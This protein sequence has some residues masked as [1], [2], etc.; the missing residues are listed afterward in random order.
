MVEI[1]MMHLYYSKIY[2]E[3]TN[4]QLINTAMKK[5]RKRK[6]PSKKGK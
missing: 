4:K 2:W 1:T 6:G 5:Y 3:I